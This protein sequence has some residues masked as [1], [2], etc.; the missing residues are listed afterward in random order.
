M[1]FSGFT[2]VP[3][4]LVGGKGRTDC[5]AVFVLLLTIALCSLFDLGVC[6]WSWWWCGGYAELSA[7]RNCGGG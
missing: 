2:A 5:C 6:G 1:P 3:M 7:I 4:F